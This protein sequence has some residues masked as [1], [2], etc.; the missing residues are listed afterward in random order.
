VK[1]NNA[2]KLALSRETLVRLDGRKLG[3]AAGAAWSDDSICPTT[4]PSGNGFCG[5]RRGKDPHED[6]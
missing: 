4:G 6:H 1:K 5:G 2:K 3:L